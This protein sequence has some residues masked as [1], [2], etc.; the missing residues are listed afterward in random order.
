MGAVYNIEPLLREE[1]KKA[2]Q[3]YNLMNYNAASKNT[4]K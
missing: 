1:R 2:I 4:E 3:I